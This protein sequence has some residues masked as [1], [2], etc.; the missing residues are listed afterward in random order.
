MKKPINLIVWHEPRD[1]PPNQPVL[2]AYSGDEGIEYDVVDGEVIA[3]GSFGVIAW[4]KL[5]KLNIQGATDDDVRGLIYTAQ[6]HMIEER[7]KYHGLPE[8]ESVLDANARRIK[9]AL[10]AA[11]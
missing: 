10:E 2:A 4:A 8:Y 3:N 6:A 1:T 11:K 7:Q 9:E 5:P